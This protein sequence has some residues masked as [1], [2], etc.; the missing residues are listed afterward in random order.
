MA[1]RPLPAFDPALRPREGVSRL[2]QPLSYNHAPSP[3]LEP[4]VARLYAIVVDAPATHCLTS[5]LMND[6]AMIRIQTRGAWTIETDDGRQAYDR[7]ALLFGG[8]TR[9][10]P[11]TVTGSFSSIGIALKPGAM[12]ALARIDA[13]RLVNRIAPLA[14]LGLDGEAAMAAVEQAQSAQDATDRLEDMLRE[15]IARVGA[16]PPDAITAAFDRLTFEAPD[17]A[18]TSFIQAHAVSQS[19]LTRIIKRDFGTT[20]KQALRRA[21]VMDMASYLRGVAV[22]AE[23]EA[24][25]LRYYDQS[26]LIRDF[27]DFFGLTPRRFLE[28]PLPL[29]TFALDARQTRRLELLDRLE[30]GEPRPWAAD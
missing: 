21:R 1:K 16:Q 27:T 30:P 23:G 13:S 28:T 10:I 19:Q 9:M 11:V 12:Q 25:Q 6:T 17:A 29:L 18:I 14:A 20:P 26:H 8:H 7:C 3:D 5:G 4:W 22:E 15:L 2:G 24:M